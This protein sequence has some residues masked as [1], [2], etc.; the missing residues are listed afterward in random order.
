MATIDWSLAWLAVLHY[1]QGGFNGFTT[2]SDFYNKFEPTD[3]RREA[4][5]DYPNA[6]PNPGRRVNVG[7]L[8]GQQYD[9]FTD[10]PFIR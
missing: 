8:I 2:L 7:F 4:V 3:K 5:Y 10:D 6:P 1:T 9:L